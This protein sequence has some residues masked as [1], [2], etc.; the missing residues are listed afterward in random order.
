MPPIQRGVKSSRHRLFATLVQESVGFSPTLFFFFPPLRS[1]VKRAER[2]RGEERGMSIRGVRGATTA[3]ANAREA[4]HAAT[5]ELLTA[6]IDANGLRAPDIASAIFTVTRDLT[7]AFPAAAARELGW[8]RVALLDMP[9]PRVENDLPRC[10][11]V[12]IHWNTARTQ[13]EIRHMY[14]RGARGLRPDLEEEQ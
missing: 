4:I 8:T 6:L 9:A 5:R 13:N 10:I 7:A 2:G 14:L 1:P 11:R 3:D 12:L